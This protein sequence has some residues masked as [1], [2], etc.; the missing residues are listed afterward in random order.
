MKCEIQT[1]GG[2]YNNCIITSHFHSCMIFY[3]IS[4]TTS[5]L[6]LKPKLSCAALIGFQ[7]LVP[8][9]FQSSPSSINY[10]SV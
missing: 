10:A 7:S 2:Y 1:A 4:S 6:L 5:I 9:Q 3:L 8:V